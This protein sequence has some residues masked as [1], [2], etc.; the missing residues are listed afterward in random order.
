MDCRVDVVVPG[1]WW[2]PLTYAAERPLSTGARVRVPLGRGTRV[3]FVLGP[4]KK[5]TPPKNLRT[6][7]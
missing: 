3:G 5:K 2:T 6:V 7:A 4:A 1:P